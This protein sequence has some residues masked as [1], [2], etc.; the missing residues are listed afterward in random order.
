MKKI[1]LALLIACSANVLA[2]FKIN[3]LM[4]NNVS[5]HMDSYYNYSMWVEIYNSSTTQSFNLNNFY[6]S[7]N[8]SENRKWQAPNRNVAANGFTI[9]YFERSSY[10]NH[11]NF[12][13]EPEGGVLYMFSSS[14]SIVDSVKYGAQKR[15]ISFGR[16]TDGADEWVF[17]DVPSPAASNNGKKWNSLTCNIPVFTKTG[18]FYS[19][20]QSIAFAT[21]EVGDT[22]YYTLNGNEPTRTNAL[23]YQA[24][25][26]INISRTTVLRA[27]TVSKNKLS[28]E[29]ATQTY[30]INER[31]FNLP[32]VSIVTTPAN[33]TNNLIGIYV[34][35]T[36]GITGNGMDTPANWNMDWDRPANF[37]LYDKNRQQQL[38]QELDIAIAG[39]WTR[40]NGQKSLKIQPKKK[41][42]NNRL[43]YDFFEATKPG[44]KY[45]DILLRNS[46]NDFYYSMMRD[47][48]AQSVVMKRMN[49]DYQAYEP[50]ICFMNGE[51]YGIQNLRERTNEDYIYSNY[52]L[53][54]SEIDLL[55][56][57]ELNTDA[58][59]KALTNYVSNN[60]IATE[61]VYNAVCEMMDMDNFISYM[62]S[63]M[64][65][66]NTDWPHNNIK[67]WRKKEGGKWRWLLYDTDFGFNLYDTNLHN[68]NSVTYVLGENSSNV[69]AAWSTLLMRRLVL[70]ETFRNRLIDKA[71]VQLS[72]TFTPLRISNIIDSLARPIQTEITY[73]KNKWGSYRG[74]T[75]DISNMKTFGTNRSNRMFEFLASR[76]LGNAPTSNITLS[77]NIANAQYSMNNELIMDAT[78][79]IRTYNNRPL[80][81]KAIAPRGYAFSH[82]EVSGATATQ[83]LIA[84]NDTWRYFDGN[85]MPAANWYTKNYSDASWKT[86]IAPLGYGNRGETTTI[87]WGTDANNK[88]ITA[89]F[90]KNVQISNVSAKSN[91]VLNVYVDDATAV[92]V[93]GTEVGRYNLPAGPLTFNTVANTFNNVE[94]A[95][96]VVPANLLLEGDNLIAAEVHQ[97]SPTS[98]D[99]HFRL[100]MSYSEGSNSNIVDSE[101]F[102][103]TLSKNISLKAIFE[104][105]NEPIEEEK[106][107]IN[108]IVASNNIIRDEFG[109]KDDY[110]EL[111]NRSDE[112]VNIAGWH[113]TDTP[114]NRTLFTFASTD[115]SKTTIAPKSHLMLWADS[116]P[117]QGILHLNFKLSKEGETIILSR[118]NGNA[119]LTVDSVAYPDM[120]QNMSFAR[121]PDGNNVWA[122]QTPT[123]NASNLAPNAAE[124][125]A[126]NGIRVYPIVAT[127][128]VYVEGASMHTIQIFD[129]QGKI[130][131]S[132]QATESTVRI[133]LQNLRSGLYILRVNGQTFK[134]I[135]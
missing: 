54:E 86:G 71:S 51:Y 120:P 29:I 22:I 105:S 125:L 134:L 33:L 41:F 74:F 88:N 129:L 108:E 132:Q 43:L 45:K 1:I 57:A 119:L 111:Y 75:N 102:N 30:F 107:V 68:F 23:L 5:A 66:G 42:G 14:G 121:V 127:S 27:I 10:T 9:L 60:N 18:G 128:H 53:D 76:F 110:I 117:E 19:G 67:A 104:T 65:F 101:I 59:F 52:G 24:G 124:Q 97:N 32:V 39:G 26:N 106:I 130:V 62:L 36:N 4:T 37:E 47:A 90:R 69:P 73:H 38:N 35:G 72:T 96:F 114:A 16:K 95:T 94:L 8:K 55:E 93:N 135:K 123:P 46:G 49:L 91:F 7:N 17:F 116:Q 103:T 115:P 89:Y 2:Q 126:S 87:S 122:V 11:A 131:H 44:N 28:S 50:A 34:Q 21:P 100:A 84:E 112:A 85:A 3:E 92:Y 13:L 58:R 133:D 64:F 118:P 20:T 98:S 15:N 81:F 78:A 63:Q 12:R 70:N 61:A 83:Q 82:W 77:A 31:N 56:S 40:K 80:N 109:D 99:L 48:V 6:F 79:N 113:I 25:S